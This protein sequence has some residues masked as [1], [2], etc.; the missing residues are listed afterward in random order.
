MS[1][2]QHPQEEGFDPKRRGLFKAMLYTGAA[3]AGLSFLG[4]N[5]TSSANTLLSSTAGSTSTSGS[6]LL[7]TLSG[8]TTTSTSSSML[9]GGI[10]P[11]FRIDVHCHHIPDFYRS[12]LSSYG[13]TTAGGVAIPDWTPDLAISFMNKY[14]IQTQV[15]S[16]SEPGV[17]YIPDANGRVSMARQINDYTS[18]ELMYTSKSA[19][20]GVLEDLRYCPWVI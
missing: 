4:S 16:I 12:S 8:T 13:I 1:Q 7:S 17:Y 11:N 9:S 2:E 15:L 6:T 18:Q 20:S 19:W 14:G 10:G 5:T 3:T